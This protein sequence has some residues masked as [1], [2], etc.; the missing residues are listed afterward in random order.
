M[1][2][3]VELNERTREPFSLWLRARVD[4]FVWARDRRVRS[5]SSVPRFSEPVWCAHP[6]RC[7]PACPRLAETEEIT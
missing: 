2:S 4:A 7:S 1:P 6:D 5:L 3:W